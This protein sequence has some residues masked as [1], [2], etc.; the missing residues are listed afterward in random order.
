MKLCA[1]QL[2]CGDEHVNGT[3]CGAK[4]R[5]FIALHVLGCWIKRRVKSNW[6]C[7]H[8][9]F[10]PGSPHFRSMA[11]FCCIRIWNSLYKKARVAD[12]I[13]G[14]QLAICRLFFF[15]FFRLEV[16]RPSWKLLWSA[17]LSGAGNPLSPHVLASSC[18]L[19]SSAHRVE[20]S[21]ELTLSSQLVL[22]FTPSGLG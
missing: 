10:G 13:Q 17:F 20:L 16:M 2:S 14:L 6:M 7:F 11:G 3:C 4:S 22:S 19:S 1:D 9:L 21:S 12:R 5:S 15:F 8:S 18:S